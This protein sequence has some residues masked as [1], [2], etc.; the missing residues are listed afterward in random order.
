MHKKRIILLIFSLI[1][2]FLFIYFYKFN[3]EINLTKEN[4]DFINQDK[5]LNLIFKM[6][7][8]FDI[9]VRIITESSM[10][11]LIFIAPLIVTIPSLKN[12]YNIYKSGMIK[13]I[14]NTRKKYDIFMNN[15]IFN[16]YKNALILPCIFI[17]III[18]CCCYS[19]FSLTEPMLFSND[20]YFNSDLFFIFITII[21]LFLAGIFYINIGLIIINNFNNFYLLNIFIY[22]LFLLISIFSELILGMGLYFITKVEVFGNIFSFFNIWFN[23]D[24]GNNLFVTLYLLTINTISI[25]FVKK[26]FKDIEIVALNV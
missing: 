7:N 16:S 26:K 19:Q 25:I 5:G 15:M 20:A 24:C 9:Y 10:K 1:S 3:M 13:T 2:L 4:I 14:V 12:F 22:I 21:N 17:Y 8:M 18:V 6:P 23:C 11:I